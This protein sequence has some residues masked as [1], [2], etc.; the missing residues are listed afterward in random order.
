M[1]RI[2]LSYFAGMPNKNNELVLLSK[3]CTKVVKDLVSVSCSAKDAVDH[4]EALL[5]TEKL[6]ELY[7]ELLLL[8]GDGENITT[9]IKHLI[10]QQESLQEYF[11]LKEEETRRLIGVYATR[12][13][14]L[15]EEIGQRVKQLNAKKKTLSDIKAGLEEAMLFHEK[16][17][18]TRETSCNSMLTEEAV[19]EDC[20]TKHYLEFVYK[21]CN[22]ENESK[23]PDEEATENVKADEHGK[24]CCDTMREIADIQSQIFDSKSQ[25]DDLAT[26][27]S[28]LYKERVRYHDEVTLI[29]EKVVFLKQAVEFWSLLKELSDETRD[30]TKLLT[31]IIEKASEKPRIASANATIKLAQT[32][33]EAWE[34]E[35]MEAEK[36]RSHLLHLDFICIQCSVSSREMPYVVDNSLVCSDCFY[37]T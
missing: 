6:R 8:R 32:F 22:S 21:P 13:L 12:E 15:K 5:S 16:D 9:R 10:K 3:K 28:L 26:N 24:Y 25:I 33:L 29:K 7:S 19:C 35:M 37:L 14:E 27:L 2:V 20:H 11:I 1:F 17:L 30:Y 31:K 23:K 34:A 18:A 36:G 4:P